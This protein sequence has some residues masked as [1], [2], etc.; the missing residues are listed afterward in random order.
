MK[1]QK[2][3]LFSPQEFWEEKQV[4]SDMLV[5]RILLPIPSTQ[6]QCDSPE[7]NA[8]SKF[9]SLS[10]VFGKAQIPFFFLPVKLRIWKTT[11]KIIC[12][13][14]KIMNSLLSTIHIQ[15]VWFFF[16]QIFCK[17]YLGKKFLME[18]IEARVLETL[19]LCRIQ[20]ILEVMLFAIST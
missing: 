18:N 2:T 8:S 16:F 20:N 19:L 9:I 6:S 17:R 7:W 1:Q 4:C 11:W 14:P 13:L 12:F 3:F 10:V 5:L 15:F